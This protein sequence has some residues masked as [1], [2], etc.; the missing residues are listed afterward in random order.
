MVRSSD[1]VATS[2]Q[3]FNWAKLGDGMCALSGDSCR[4]MSVVGKLVTEVS[5][6][7]LS[8][9]ADIGFRH[10]MEDAL[11]ILGNQQIDPNR[12][13]YVLGDLV[14]LFRDASRGSQI[15]SH[16]KFF[17]GSDD[18]SA[19]EDFERLDRYLR[20]RYQN[21]WG[22]LL[23]DVSGALDGLQKGV[24]VSEDA[25]QKSQEVLQE[26]V[27]GIARKHAYETAPAPREIR[28]P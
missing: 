23:D 8:S 25:R 5:M 2:I 20:H 19:F 6:E 22:Q 13:A 9:F 1:S 21:T 10:I 28:M 4:C 24:P 16:R 7:D 18:K 17:V 11:A 12:R 26:L 14:R 3:R 15:A 27:K